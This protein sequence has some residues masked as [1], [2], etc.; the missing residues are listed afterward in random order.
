MRCNKCGFNGVYGESGLCIRCHRDADD[1]DKVLGKRA[2]AKHKAALEPDN[3][4]KLVKEI[5]FLRLWGDR[6]EVRACNRK[7]QR[8][9]GEV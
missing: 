8:G 7:A 1:L 6:N 4:Y 3:E 5:D 2:V 9:R